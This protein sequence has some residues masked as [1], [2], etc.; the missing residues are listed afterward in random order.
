MGPRWRRRSLPIREA[1][2]SRGDQ[3]LYA[4]LDGITQNTM[5][6]E[7]PSRRRHGLDRREDHDLGAEGGREYVRR[8]LGARC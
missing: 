4:T 3:Y 6:F 1:V 7:R 2:V 5:P 8:M